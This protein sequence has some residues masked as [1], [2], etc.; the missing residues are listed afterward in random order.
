MLGALTT[1]L[2]FQL[3]GEVIVQFGGWPIPGPVIGLL[4]LF[5]ALTLR[6]ALAEPLRDTANGILQ[7]LS[8]LFVPA[9]VGVMVHFSRV[10]GEWLPILA[11]T[12][13]STAL[14]MGVSALVMQWM[15]RGREA[16]G[17]PQGKGGEGT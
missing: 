15:M 8:L 1:L 4:L 17:G 5:F 10:S 7:H 13:A 2:V 14:A 16:Q 11:A 12:V 9:G 3:I 6:G